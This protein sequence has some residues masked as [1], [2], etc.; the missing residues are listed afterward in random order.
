MLGLILFAITTPVLGIILAHNKE[1]KKWLIPFG[2]G[3]LLTTI[4]THLIP[5]IMQ[6]ESAHANG[7][8]VVVGFGLYFLLSSCLA[9]C[10]HDEHNCSN[11]Q[12]KGISKLLVTGFI[13]HAILDGLAIYSLSSSNV[14]DALIGLSVHRAI[15][16]IALVAL[17]LTH[18][19]PTKVIY[20]WF[21]LIIVA[22]LMGFGAGTI[23][24]PIATD[25]LTAFVCGTLIYILA[26]DMIPETHK[27]NRREINILSMIV[28][29]AVAYTL[30][31]FSVHGA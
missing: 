28:G 4:F 26:A 23:G 6:N 18:K 8:A 15:D 5:E 11:E 7:F 2:A 3:L 1:I 9:M 25:T 27:S 10:P 31:S 13:V 30:S 17:A 24:L 20:E 12:H 19:M 22:T 14:R 16:G 21:G 29:I